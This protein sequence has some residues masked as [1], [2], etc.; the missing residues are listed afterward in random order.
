VDYRERLPPEGIN[1]SRENPLKEFAILLGGLV[2][3][4]A[5][6]IALV[7]A[8]A[9]RIAVYVPFEMEQALAGSYAKEDAAA[10][11]EVMRYLT[12]LTERLAAVSDLP[13]GMRITP[14]FA[15]EDMINAFATLGGHIVIFR[16]LLE[17][18]PNENAL[19]MVVAHEIAHV[20]HRD[21]IASLGRGVLVQLALNAIAGGGDADLVLGQTGLLTLLTFSRDMEEDADAQAMRALNAYYGHVAGAA[22]LFEVL[23]QGD[24]A[25]G[26]PEF[27]STHPLDDSRI[28]HLQELTASAGWSEQGATKPLPPEIVSLSGAD[29]S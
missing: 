29:P 23:H 12:G 11:D 20:K 19:A 3:A 22:E 18:M 2:L 10:P 4:T 7:A 6:L 15:D 21:P 13:E 16:G 27:F 8:F 24:E 9:E 25:V 5:I 1:A 28:E 26:L 14:H 17:R